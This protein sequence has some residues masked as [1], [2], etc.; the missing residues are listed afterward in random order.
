M[1][2][3]SK[4]FTIDGSTGR[5]NPVASYGA[6]NIIIERKRQ[7]WSLNEMV[8]L[9]WNNGSALRWVNSIAALQTNMMLLSQNTFLCKVRCSF[10][11]ILQ[12]ILH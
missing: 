4:D 1:I 3:Q 5:E 8:S 9:I 10:E 6:A 2:F 7:L 12:I 11:E